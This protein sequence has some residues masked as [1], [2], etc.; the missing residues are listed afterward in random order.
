[1]KL[2]AK[3]FFAL[4]AALL[5]AAM[6]LRP[7]KNILS[8][9]KPVSSGQEKEEARE[10]R[11]DQPDEA[12]K[13]RVLQL[14]DEKKEIPADGLLKGKAHLEVMKAALV[15][16]AQARGDD[17]DSMTVAGLQP[18]DWIPIG[19]NNSG[20]R[21]RAIAIDPGNANNIWVGSVA[22][23][24]WRTTNA[25]TSWA[26]VNDFMADLAISSLVINPANPSVM[27]AGT[28][29]GFALAGNEGEPI[30]PDGLR[31]LGV[32]KSTDA[33][34]TWN[35]L[36]KT[37]PADATVCGT[38]G[39]NCPW[40]Y[41][42]R[43][44]ISPNGATLLA[45]TG[46]GI[47][48]STD[49]GATWT[50]GAGIPAALRDVDFDPTNNQK[51][52]ASNN[53]AAVYSTDGGQNWTS[54]TFDQ[55]IGG[56]VEVAYAPSSPN[57]V[58]ASVNTN[59]GEIYESINGGQSYN[60]VQTGSKFLGTQGNY[61]NIIWVNPQDPNF[62]IVGGV[63]LWKSTNAASA[64]PI[65]LTQISK[66]QCGSG[67]NGACANTS[68][69][70]DQHMILAVPGFNNS[71]NKRVYFS[72]D[73]GIFRADDVQTVGQQNGWTNLNNNLTITQFYSGAVTYGSTLIGGTQ[74]N[75]N[76]RNPADTT[77][78]PP[79]NSVGWSTP[80]GGEGDGGY[81][82]ADPGDDHFV[83]VEYINLAISRSVNG[84]S[85]FGQI[86]CNPGNVVAASPT[87][88]PPLAA[89]Q[90]TSNTGIADVNN[91]A[92]FI[93][94]FVVDPSNPGTMLA[95][96]KSLWR[97][98]DVK[99]AQ[100]PTWAAIKPQILD[101][102]PTPQPVPISA[103][104]VAPNN[105]DL[106]VVGHNGGQIFL[107]SNGTAAPPTW[108]EIDTASLP[109]R[110]VTHLAID[111]TR[112]PN[113]IYVTFG[114]FSADNV[115]VTKDL[116]TSW[117][118]ITGTGATGLPDVPVRSLWI[119]KNIP[120]FLYVGTEVGLFA[121]ED[122][123]TTWQLPQ[124]GPANVSVEAIFQWLRHIVAATHGRGMYIAG[125][126]SSVV[127]PGAY[128][129]NSAN[130]S[131]S[132]MNSSHWAGNPG[133]FP[134]V[135][136][137]SISAGDGATDDLVSIGGL[138]ASVSSIG[139][140]MDPAAQTGIN[141]DTGANGAIT[142]GAIQIQSSLNKILSIY[143]STSAFGTMTLT[144]RTVNGI[145]NTIMA[146]DSAQRFDFGQGGPGGALGLALGNPINNVIQVNGSGA[147]TINTDV[148]GPGRQL[149]KTG[150][151]TLQFNGPSSH[152]GGTVLT[153]GTITF[154]SSGSAIGSTTA[155]LT[156]NGGT[157]DMTGTDQ[158][159]G[160]L[161][162]TGGTI[163]NNSTNSNTGVLT[164]GNGG[165][166]GSYGGV[167]TD[168]TSGNQ[169]VVLVKVGAGTQMLSGSNTQTAGT[170]VNGGSLLVY[171][172]IG[173]G[174]GTNIV[175]IPSQVGAT[176][177][178]GTTDGSGGISGAL[179]DNGLYNGSAPNS[180]AP[181]SAT[182][183]AGIL[184]VGS[185]DSGGFLNIDIGGVTAGTSYD[186]LAVAGSVSFYG[187]IRVKFLNNFQNSIQPA[188]VFDI[189]TTVTGT[190][191]PYFG[192]LNNGRLYVFGTQ[193]SFAVQVINNGK[194]MRLN[195]F[196]RGS[197]TFDSWASAHNLSGAD[198]TP[199]AD[200]DGDGLSNLAEYAFGRDPNA[201]ESGALTQTQ[202]VTDAGI[203][204]LG[205]T[206][207]RPTGANAATGITYTPRANDRSLHPGFVVEC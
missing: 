86:Y 8:G 30:T 2:L 170:T 137:N 78:D 52:I 66:W 199:T 11:P 12:L 172:A 117:T 33:G 202:I 200:P 76:L 84:G 206:Y 185:L 13:F 80:V 35:Q 188:D 67:Q 18:G 187:A 168:H 73:G 129:W 133:H 157:F 49:A 145:D 127:P 50:Q 147:I 134:G 161:N 98:K 38:P 43:L 207:A 4:G 16:R 154:A 69:H 81:V 155:P 91:G 183:D 175:F 3:L 130:L 7:E 196:Q 177:G 64:N 167:I 120:N 192:N 143:K 166:S 93:A 109:K 51:A 142:L 65:N 146:N 118:D 45:A 47:W 106:V 150:P 79:W 191:S 205:L 55:T 119:N 85:T 169:Q 61:D 139:I 204:Y 182:G 193:G 58:F 95:G 57:I 15:S 151:G 10:H 71:T 131:N 141:N 40:S 194:A 140:Y 179:R 113:W 173:S 39:I 186:R 148:T 122:A 90:C 153:G 181:S 102:Q 125:N 171:N 152:D 103:I 14:Q 132:W 128:T 34:L 101:A 99:T 28:G 96:G 121:S 70:A 165:A 158:T 9:S 126:S 68:A 17:P 46:N 110:F 75:G 41:V 42:Y 87:P 100:V 104:G 189:F 123:G 124:G 105:P 25:G 48:R 115:Y 116:G 83:Y 54:A 180:I 201:A 19:P 111:G 174:T 108:S 176:F 94:P 107:S 37:N 159:I 63:D 20:G 97:A 53:G 22:G 72:N 164:V 160:A 195:D 178:G 62:V 23:G 60:R 163:A 26:P 56:R 5:V 6:L 203:K 1:M 77:F 198:A 27:Y 24:I 44:A 136:N 162:G 135:D 36:A 88:A 32:F 29:E 144:G 74:D 31:G 190:I 156:I 114:G 138:S 197:V 21:I 184:H 92:N 149:E 82:A 59:G 89:G 112:V